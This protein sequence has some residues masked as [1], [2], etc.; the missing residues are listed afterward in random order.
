M[1]KAVQLIGI[2]HI[3]R[4]RG[5]DELDRIVGLEIGGLIG[6][7]RIGRGVRFVEAVAGE[8]RHQLEDIFGAA[9]LD[10]IADRAFDE[11]RFLR[12][13]LLLDLLA[14]GAAEKIRLAEREAGEH[15]GDLHHLLLVDDD[16]V[17]L[18]QD[19]LDGIDAGTQAPPAR[20]CG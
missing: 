4:H 13:H 18:L 8:L 1:C 17:G 16:A 11:A 10:A 9:A 15:L 7:Q 5:G 12:R 20:V 6:D 14:H 19:R 2:G 3:E